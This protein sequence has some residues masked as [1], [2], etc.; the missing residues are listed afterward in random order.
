MI[1]AITAIGLVTGIPTFFV[2][3]VVVPIASNAAELISA[4]QFAAKKTTETA[5]VG[6]ATC[7]GAAC[8]N[9]T[10]CLGVFL[11]LLYFEGL[12]WNFFGETI[13]NLFAI[14]V[15]GILGQKRIFR[16]TDAVLV[17]SLYFVSIAIVAIGRAY[18]Q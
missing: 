8:M 11:A 18:L 16:L 3:F 1:D 10:L 12:Q 4:C 5:T 2:S 17:G 7:Y 6:I 13:G 15:M 9:N 14:L